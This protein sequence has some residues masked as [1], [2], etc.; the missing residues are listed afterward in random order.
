MSDL[1]FT[2]NAGTSKRFLT[3]GKYCNDNIVVT[4]TGSS[5]GEATDLGSKT[6][7]QN[8]EYMATDDSLDG[9]SSVTVNVQPVLQ[10]LVT[11]TPDDTQHV[12][13][14]E[15]GYDGLRRV[16]VRAVPTQEK[17]VTENG[18][19][20]PDAGKY[21]S[22]VVVNV[23]SSGGGSVVKT[24]TTTSAT[25]DTGLSEIEY[26]FM[27]KETVTTTGLIML[28]YNGT[29][30]LYLHAN[31]WAT[32]SYGSKNVMKGQ[33][34]ATVNGGSITVPGTSETT[35]ALSSGV[36]YYWTAVGKE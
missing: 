8:G 13:D 28:T 23:P 18:T 6:I 4:A 35:G 20:T 24:G 31:Q 22:S 36:T 21:L 12:I 29:D 17:T 7:T 30:T 2:I 34:A 33:V 27:Y 1:N 10:S 19:V 32:T 14:P 3:G 11:I 25:I 9:Y 16:V 5:G 15:D 26:F